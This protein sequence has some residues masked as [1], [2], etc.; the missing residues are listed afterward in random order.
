MTYTLCLK[1]SELPAIE[2]RENGSPAKGLER[3]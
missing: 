3:V 1:H 2:N